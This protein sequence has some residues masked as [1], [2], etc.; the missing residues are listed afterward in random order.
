[1]Y[2]HLRYF[3]KAEVHYKGRW[4]KQMLAPIVFM[5]KKLFTSLNRDAPLPIYLPKSFAPKMIVIRN[6]TRKIKNNTLAIL[7][8]PAAIPVNPKS[9]A[10]IAM[11]KKVIDHLSIKFLFS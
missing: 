1:M 5:C 3:D 2:H 7:A 10:M 11:T 8:A 6:N 9:A 4:A